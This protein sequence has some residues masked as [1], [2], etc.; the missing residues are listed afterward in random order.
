MNTTKLK[1]GLLL[2]SIDVPAWVYD[3][4]QRIA[5]K[6]SSEFVLVILNEGTGKRNKID[7]SKFVYSIFNRI[8]EKIFTKE[9][10]PFYLKNITQIINDVPVLKVFP[11]EDGNALEIE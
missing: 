6:K 8:D 10:D 7:Q 3:V 9:P 11:H 1:L 4:L 2:D 5:I